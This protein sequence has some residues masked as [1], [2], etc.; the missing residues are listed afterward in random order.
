MFGRLQYFIT[1]F[2]FFLSGETIFGITQ[3]PKEGHLTQFLRMCGKT[4]FC[5]FFEKQKLDQKFLF[6]YLK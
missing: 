5:F 1:V 2:I 4:F 3:Q 6:F